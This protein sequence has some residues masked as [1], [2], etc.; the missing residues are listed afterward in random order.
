[1]ELKPGGF[2]AVRF[3]LRGIF[4]VYLGLGLAEVTPV[5][6]DWLLKEMRQPLFYWAV[7]STLALPVLLIIEFLQRV[8]KRRKPLIDRGLWIDATLV[9]AWWLYLAIGVALTAARPIW[10]Q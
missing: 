8:L 10:A 6:G 4:V 2:N 9:F 1:M 7:G 3:L 5:L